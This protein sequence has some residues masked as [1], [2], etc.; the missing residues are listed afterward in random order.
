[1]ELT[2]QLRRTMTGGTLHS[3]LS[4]AQQGHERKYIPKLLISTAVG[5]ADPNFEQSFAAEPH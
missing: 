2:L 1:M 3:G 4:S 5:F